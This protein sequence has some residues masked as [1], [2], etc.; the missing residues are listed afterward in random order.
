MSVRYIDDEGQERKI[1]GN[2]IPP[3]ASDT[4]FGTVML[5][6]SNSET[7]DTKFALPATEK[8]PNIAGTLAAQI[9]DNGDHIT[10]L[11][12]TLANKIVISESRKFSVIYSA[13]TVGTRCISSDINFT[14]TGYMV[15][16]IVLENNSNSND[17]SIN[18]YSSPN[19]D[20][21]VKCY[22]ATGNAVSNGEITYRVI[23]LKE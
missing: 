10:E 23:Y 22:R 9:K 3:I 2:E 6:H 14:K 18:M 5:T 4:E 19:G 17:F 16:G 20:G 1:A 13:G 11:N 21:Q 15:I 7:S 8:N 12:N